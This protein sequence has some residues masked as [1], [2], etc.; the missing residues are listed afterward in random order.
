MPLQP[1]D[2]FNNFL[3]MADVHLILEKKNASDLVMPSKLTTIL[4][5]GGNVIVT[6]NAGSSL[7]H[8]I[9]NNNLGLVI[10]PENVNQLYEAIV[11]VSSQK[12][13]WAGNAR[14]FATS[15]LSGSMIMNKFLNNIGVS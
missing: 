5:V 7:Y 3:N 10:E 6:A 13:D 8:V 2:E 4:A 14:T 1:I 12:S 11:H 15:N 9:K